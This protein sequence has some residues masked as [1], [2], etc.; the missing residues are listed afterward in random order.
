MSKPEQ[1][2]RR[3]PTTEL[4]A[5][6]KRDANPQRLF[7]ALVVVLR[8]ELRV[9]FR[10]A[11]MQSR[12]TFVRDLANLLWEM[13]KR[14]AIRKLQSRSAKDVPKHLGAVH[15]FAVDDQGRVGGSHKKK[16]QPP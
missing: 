11:L 1:G 8:D 12:I 15:G 2:K 9:T 13:D 7:S 10:N 4:G 14:S 5:G 6:T 3:F 16:A